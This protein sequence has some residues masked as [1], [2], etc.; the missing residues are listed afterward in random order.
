MIGCA[1]Y[2]EGHWCTIQWLAERYEQE[3]EILNAFFE[4]V[5]GYKYVVHFNGNQF[6]IP[7]LEQKCQQYEFNFDF[8]NFDGL[9]IYKRIKPYKTFMKLEDCRQKTLQ[10][11][12]G[13]IRRDRLDGG[14]LINYYHEFVVNKDEEIM[15][16]ILLHNKEDV[17]GC[18]Y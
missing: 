7:F 11:F 5:R 3:E 16:A 13:M 1:Y 17:E 4:F 6:D 14:E 8:G 2:S 12:L 15:E 18:L 10:T 9:D